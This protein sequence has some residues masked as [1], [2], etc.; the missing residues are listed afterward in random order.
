MS[1]E[2][3]NFMCPSS[4]CEEG[5]ILL[6]IV[7]ENGKVSIASGKIVINKSFV[8]QAK[9]GGIPEERFRFSNT[10]QSK[11]CQ[12]WVEGRCS[13]IDF[14]TNALAEKVMVDNNSVI[15]KKCAIRPNCRWFNQAGYQACLVCPE[16]VTLS[17]VQTQKN[18]GYGHDG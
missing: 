6:G 12:Q 15:N 16:I 3:S 17:T 9:K 8:D 7:K 4:H 11:K 18:R 1:K 5:A 2:A 14:A 10:C 13:V